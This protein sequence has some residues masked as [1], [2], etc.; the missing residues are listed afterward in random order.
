MAGVRKSPLELQ[1]RPRNW[2]KFGSVRYWSRQR[3]RS[4][5]ELSDPA[6]TARGSIDLFYR[7]K[8]VQEP[9]DIALAGRGLQQML[10]IFAYLY[11]HRRSVLLVDEP[12]AHLEIL[13]QKQVYVLPKQLDEKVARL[14]LKKIGAH[15]T[16][17]TKEQAEYINVPVEGPYKPNYYRY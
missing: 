9:L 6:E 13:R 1:L 12:D 7:Q 8:H 2:L 3:N 4:S 11:S 17:L 16:E 15:L 14:H 5:V 10:L